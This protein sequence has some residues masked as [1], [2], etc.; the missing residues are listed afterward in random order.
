MGLHTVKIPEI[1]GIASPG[2]LGTVHEEVWSCP[3]YV[4]VR[5]GL[6]YAFQSH[7]VN[8]AGLAQLSARASLGQLQSC[9]EI[10]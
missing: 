8:S 4:I 5:A 7:A 2:V 3:R 10:A 1:P 9:C 6:L